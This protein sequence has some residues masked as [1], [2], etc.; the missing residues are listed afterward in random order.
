MTGDAS[1]DTLILLVGVVIGAVVFGFIGWIIGDDK[2]RGGAGFGWGFL[3]G[4][5]G[6]IIAAMMSP[7]QDQVVREQLYM[8]RRVAEARG[9]AAPGWYP[10]PWATDSQR[11][12]DGSAWT[13]HTA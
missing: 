10:D 1:I 2:G 12:W 5:I 13:S 4:P 3:L 6:L 9:A 8:E 7:S 11:Y